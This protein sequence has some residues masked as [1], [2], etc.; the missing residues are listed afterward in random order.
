MRPLL[1]LTA[2]GLLLPALLAIAATQARAD[3]LKCA[4]P[5]YGDA[6]WSYARLKE[7][8]KNIDEDTIDDL[9]A[10][11][12]RAK[13]EHVGR[14]HFHKLG[15]SDREFAREGTTQLAARILAATHGGIQ[16]L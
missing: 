6:A 10:K 8:F 16:V 3:D 4:A 5:P 9:L 12:C 11:L 2:S 1:R 15:I 13:F 14:R 7:R